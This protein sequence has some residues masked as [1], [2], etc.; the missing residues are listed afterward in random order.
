MGGTYDPEYYIK[1]YMEKHPS[2][3]DMK[4]FMEEMAII[5]SDTI[6]PYN[7]TWIETAV[8][9]FDEGLVN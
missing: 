7:H 5:K 4:R 3:T 8:K 1:L 2:K 6:S 9:D